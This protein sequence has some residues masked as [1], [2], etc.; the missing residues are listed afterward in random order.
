[1]TYPQT[2][3]SSFYPLLAS[4]T[5]LVVTLNP[6]HR[7]YPLHRHEVLE[8]SLVVSGRG[9]EWVNGLPHAMTPGAVTLIMP[10]QFH[11]I[12]SDGPEPLLLLNCMFGLELLLASPSAQERRL[13]EAL[14]PIDA[15]EPYALQ[16]S[17]ADHL[18]MEALFR[19][20]LAEFEQDSLYR[21]IVL[22]AKLL[23]MLA[24]LERHRAGLKLRPPAAAGGNHGLAGR[25]LLYLHQH[26]QSELTL[27]E[28]Q[29]HFHLSRTRLCAVLR[30]HTGKSFV[31]LLR[32][33]RLRHACSLLLS[34][35]MLV[36][37]IALEAGFQSSK[38]FFRVFRQAK[39]MT[40]RAYIAL[41][42][43]PQ[44]E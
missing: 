40:P 10:H 21:H 41:H 30:Q 31:D 43:R 7:H 38:T 4:E 20:L 15:A 17:P 19:E 35:D 37:D 14:L 6:I 32:E 33:I 28:L 23:E 26:Y 42:R 16:L 39:G 13:M 44:A 24:R 11:E 9:T 8:L 25:L 22:K 29:T 36:E 18:K 12:T 27:A 1:M 3:D 34:S 2:F 5:P